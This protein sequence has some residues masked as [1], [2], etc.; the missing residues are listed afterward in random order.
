[1]KLPRLYKSALIFLSIMGPAIITAFAD[2]DAGGITTYSIVGAH[3]GYSLLW[4]LLLITF[5][6]AVVQEMCARMGVVTGKGL[7]DLIRENFGI[8]LALFA[9]L[10]L[11]FANVATTI[12]NFAGIAASCKII[13]ISKY[14]SVPVMA[15]FIWWVVLKGSYRVVERVF[16]VFC[17]AQLAYIISGF[18][19]GP[20]WG[21]AFKETFVPSFSFEPHYLLIVIATIGTTITPWMQFFIQ[22]SVV[23]K[24][25]TVKHYQYEK[26]EVFVGAFFTNFVS[27]FIIIACAATLFK[28]GIR[29]EAAA[30]AALALR[31]VAGEF[32]E[33]L[34]AIGLF[35][36]STL[37]ASIVP[38][39]SSYAIC[40]AL[41][42]ENG[43][44]KRFNEA[45]V[46]YVLYTALIAVS[47]LVVLMPKISLVFVM[48]LAQEINGFLLPVV[49]VFMLLL[50]NNKKIM[51][52]YVNSR[53]FNI[54]A[55]LT[56][57]ALIALTII[58]L[59]ATLAGKY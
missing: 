3:Y 9:M 19:A 42:F 56:T 44:D 48:L 50:V 49:L 51:G 6:L 1:M 17:L 59:V 5:S 55:I 22:S 20:D 47:A 23:S 12:S 37:T 31:P 40:E 54:I 28:Y 16:F 34:F 15:F 41:G 10:T 57:V 32:F 43:I 33:A 7:S 11:L 2:N 45:P 58:L 25:I 14:I 13:G 27:F 24:G 30:D 39:S 29:I 4:M 26:L 18:L 21:M 8:R 53:G 46:F 36:A 52:Q 38:L 35:G